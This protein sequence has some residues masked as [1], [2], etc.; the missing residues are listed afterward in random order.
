MRR[1]NRESLRRPR[2]VFQ[3]ALFWLGTAPGLIAVGCGGTGSP[4]EGPAAGGTA[5]E[6]T[7]TPAEKTLIRIAAASDLQT[8]LP[9]LIE[10]FGEGRSIKVEAVYGSSGNLARQI[11]QGPPFDVF[12]SANRK[13]VDDLVAAGKIDPASAHPYTEGV[14]VLVVRAESAAT[15]NSL[16]DLARDGVKKVA[17]ANP[18]TAPYGF[19]AKQALEKANLWDR[20]KE[21]LTQ[22]DSVRQ[23][24]QFVET[25]N[26]EAG[27]VGHS[28]AGK[29]STVKAIPVDRS[30]Y[31]PIVQSL[32]VVSGS[33]HGREANEFVRFVLGDEGQAVFKTFGFRPV[34]QEHAD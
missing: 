31:A 8:V 12:M 29:D 19:A 26:A 6:A 7:A 15:I 32:G 10:R 2:R 27:F 5:P 3:T 34:E 4:P 33:S 30:L 11:T 21:K 1:E 28:L 23:A 16:D 18:E 24:F 13:F 20:L 25:G 14:L 17:I 22:S 9:A